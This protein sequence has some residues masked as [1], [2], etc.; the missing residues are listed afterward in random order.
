ME[1]SKYCPLKIML[2]LLDNTSIIIMMIILWG[3]CYFFP[4][5]FLNGIWVSA[6]VISFAMDCI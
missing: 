4:I 6:V 3:L 1:H 2:K 5:V